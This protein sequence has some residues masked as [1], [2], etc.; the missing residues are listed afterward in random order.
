M[1][2]TNDETPIN[3]GKLLNKS[4]T[5]KLVG[6]PSDKNWSK[7]ETQNLNLNSEKKL[8]HI[9]KNLIYEK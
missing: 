6:S 9:K 1:N 5:L 7:I 8:I 3:K 2:K 4:N